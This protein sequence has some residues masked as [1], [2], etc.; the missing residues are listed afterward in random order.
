MYLEAGKYYFFQVV[1][2]QFPGPWNVGLAAKIHSLNHTSYPYQ[3][4]KE[5]QRINITSTVVREKIVSE[6]TMKVVTSFGGSI[7]RGYNH[8][9]IIIITQ[10]SE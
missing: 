8:V 6:S 1:A 3:G 7:N 9:K 2:N 5:R 4:D 10:L